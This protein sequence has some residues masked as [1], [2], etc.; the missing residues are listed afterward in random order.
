MEEREYN[1]NERVSVEVYTP[2]GVK[3]QKGTVTSY[4]WFC[5]KLIYKVLFD[6][7]IGDNLSYDCR[8]HH[9]SKLT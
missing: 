1:I 7:P 2:Q 9:L 6:E 5:G 8:Q 3:I 4:S